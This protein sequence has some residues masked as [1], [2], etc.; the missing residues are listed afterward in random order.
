[1]KCDIVSIEQYFFFRLT[2]AMGQSESTLDGRTK[3]SN[4]RKNPCLK[5]AMDS[6]YADR[7]ATGD[8]KFLIGTEVIHAHRCVLAAL[9]PKYQAQ[10]YGAMPE[11]NVIIVEDVSSAA[12]REFLQ[13][14]YADTVTL[15]IENAE[16][17]LNLVKQSLNEKLL[18]EC[19]DFLLETVALEKLCWCYQLALF[20]D[21]N[22]LKKFCEEHISIN[23]FQL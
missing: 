1:M 18:T 8:I 9:S 17:V 10:F 23:I 16:D 5:E 15:T 14:F 4:I 6:L 19:T 21:I 7:D 2:A 22:A 12:F 13:F 20:Y 3:P 11:K